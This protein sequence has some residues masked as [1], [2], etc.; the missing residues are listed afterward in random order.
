MRRDGVL[1]R[2]AV[3][4]AAQA[5]A[6]TASLVYEEPLPELDI[7]AAYALTVEGARGA[8]NRIAVGERDGGFTVTSASG[9]LRRGARL[10][11]RERAPGALPDAAA[12]RRPQR[13]R[14]CG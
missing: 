7:P 8:A 12:G 11:E 3:A 13:V 14:R 4:D 6:A 9:P 10:L 1:A 2:G 5:H